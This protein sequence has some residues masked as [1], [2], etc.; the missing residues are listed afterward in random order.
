MIGKLLGRKITHKSISADEASEM[1]QSFGI[2]VDYA[3][4]LAELDTH[5]KERKE[6]IL[7]DT[8]YKVTGKAPRN[9]EDF[10]GECVR[11]RIWV[12]E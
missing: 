3:R 4:L 11:R 7:N 10:L 2:P 1:M 5:I 9:F 8:V 6:E 12:R